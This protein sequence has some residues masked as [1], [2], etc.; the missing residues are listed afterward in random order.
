MSSEYEKSVQVFFPHQYFMGWFRDN[1]QQQF[2]E[3]VSHFLGPGYFLKYQVDAANQHDARP[4]IKPVIKRTEY[5]HGAQYTFE[6]FLLNPKNDFPLATARE[7]ARQSEVQYNPFIMCGASGSGKTHL[8]RA[9]GNEL[10]KQYDQNK[11]FLGSIEDINHLYVSRFQNDRTQARNHLLA[12]DYLLVDDFQFIQEH[13]AL[14]EEFVLLINAFYDNKKQMVFCASDKPASMNGLDAYLKSRLEWG[15]S[16]SLKQPDLDVRVKYA[17]AVCKKKKIKLSKEQILTIAQR[18]QD[19]RHLH[20]LL[21]KLVAYKNL[22]HKSIQDSELQDILRHS[23]HSPQATP[24]PKKII[25]VTAE[26]FKLPLKVMTDSSR[27]HEVVF[28][29][30]IAMF[31]CR[32][33]TGC[34]FPALGKLFG[35]KDH[36]TAMYAVKKIDKMQNEKFDVQNLVAMLKKKCLLHEES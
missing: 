14:Q 19:I 15:L 16:V 4:R 26:H 25:E 5:P 18:F 17:Q 22:M 36:S 2:E 6:T 23:S 30:Q 32:N 33:L 10:C 21:L 7:V 24:D 1:V 28:A 35:G 29:R 8:L 34:S 3:Q 11:I 31:L 9:I 12:F 20:G 13:R 27:T